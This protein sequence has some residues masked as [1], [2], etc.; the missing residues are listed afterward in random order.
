MNQP[1]LL[2]HGYIR[3]SA[4]GQARDRYQETESGEKEEVGDIRVFRGGKWVYEQRSL[5]RDNK[6][7]IAP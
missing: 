7:F 4:I 6:T 1:Q 5:R 2:Q 3:R